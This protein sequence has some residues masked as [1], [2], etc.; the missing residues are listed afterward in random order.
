MERT[1]H[2]HECEAAV[3]RPTNFLPLGAIVNK[4]KVRLGMHAASRGRTG[5]SNGLQ[6]ERQRSIEACTAT[7]PLEGA[8]N[9]V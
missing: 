9:D 5:I 4:M 1:A 3:M 2:K 8:V 6:D 7:R